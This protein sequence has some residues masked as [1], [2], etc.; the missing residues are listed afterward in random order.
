M[1]SVLKLFYDKWVTKEDTKFPL[2]NILPDTLVKFSKYHVTNESQ[3]VRILETRGFLENELSRENDKEILRFFHCNFFSYFVKYHG[4]QN[5]VDTVVD[6]G[7]VYLYPIEMK[8]YDMLWS[9]QTYQLN[10]QEY[11]YTVKEVLSDEVIQL[12]RDKKITIVAS[13]PFEPV[14]DISAVLKFREQL[15]QFGIEHDDCI[16]VVGGNKFENA[17]NLNVYEVNLPLTQVAEELDKFLQVRAPYYGGLPYPSEYVLPEDLNTSVIRQHKFLSFNR[18]LNRFHRVML[19]HT[20]LEHDLLRQGIFSFIGADIL[21]MSDNT[22]RDITNRLRE[23]FQG[24]FNANEISSFAEKIH[25]LIPYE[26]DTQHLSLEQKCGFSTNNNKKDFYLNSYINITSESRFSE[27][28]R[29]GVFFSEKTYRPIINLQPFIML[30][31]PGTLRG[32]RELGFKTF[33]PFIDESY[34]SEASRVVRFKKI[35]HEILKLSHKSIEE[36]HD[37]YYSI[38]DVLLHNQNLL[39]TYHNTNPFETIMNR[40]SYE[41][42]K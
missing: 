11:S 25:S 29:E 23:Y 10:G 12:V 16:V 34:D 27:G 9:P 38:S 31:D 7:A 35:Q 8:N 33:H 28:T 6:D 15:K 21:T 40:V 37:W 2:P 41:H 3:G 14:N 42:R 4:M 22:L 1:G 13:I 36:I 26:I 19:A 20:V 39:Q 5:V 32:L 18:S 24:Q 17:S 30:G